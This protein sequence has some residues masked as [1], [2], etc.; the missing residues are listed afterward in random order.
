MDVLA[1]V[2]GSCIVPDHGA[3]GLYI[4]HGGQ[5]RGRDCT[6]CLV[7]LVQYCQ[8]QT[9]EAYMGGVAGSYCSLDHIGHELGVV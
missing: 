5:R 3:V 2:L 1:A 6:E 4:Q 7:E 8:I 9:D